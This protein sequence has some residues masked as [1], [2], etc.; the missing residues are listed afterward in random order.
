MLSIKQ[1]DAAAAEKFCR[2]CEIEFFEGITTAMLAKD[3]EN[4]VGG[5]VF[6]LRENKMI[7]RCIEPY[8]DTL[9]T[10]G[11]LRSALFFAAN[12]NIT[13]VRFCE[14]VDE[15]TVK[16]LGF[17]KNSEEK[18]VDITNLFSNCKNCGNNE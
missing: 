8:S 3:G 9:M 1:T 7:L 6:D 13:D 11:M 17:L 18:T 5:V 12:K 14:K 16:K 15:P 10:D 2:E 4:T